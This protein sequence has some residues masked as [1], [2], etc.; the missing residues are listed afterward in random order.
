MKLD[1]KVAIVTGSSRGIG[2]AI[3]ERFAAEG[4][5]VVVNA[6]H[7]DGANRLAEEIQAQ[8]GRAIAVKA[9]V[10]KKA[11]VQDLIKKAMDGLGPIHILVNNAGIARIGLIHEMAEEDLDALQE[12]NLKGVFLCTQ[13]VLDH[14]M[15]QKYGK[16]ITSPHWP[17]LG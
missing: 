4:A 7:A 5:A 10:S 3:A 1:G 11:E 9:D 8:G 15:K 16:I 6:R 12:V 2:A 13:A 14:M 17:H